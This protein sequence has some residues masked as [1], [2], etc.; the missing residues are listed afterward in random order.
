MVSDDRVLAIDFKSNKLIPKR[1]EDTPDGLLRQM[2]AYGAAL[3]QIYPDHRIET[4][5]V[6]TET[7]EIM[8]LPHDIVRETLLATHIS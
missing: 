3:S 1:P 2:G 6:W 4:A 7:A 8:S 5:I